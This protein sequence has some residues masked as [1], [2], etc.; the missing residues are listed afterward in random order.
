MFE[1][2]P[3]LKKIIAERQKENPRFNQTILADLAHVPTP[4]ISRF[5]KSERFDIVNLFAIARALNLNV[6]DLF[7]VTEIKN[8]D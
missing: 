2:K 4:A 8:A 7:E 3:K 5:D 1:V 6:E